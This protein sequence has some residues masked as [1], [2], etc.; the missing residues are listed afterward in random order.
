MKETKHTTG[1]FSIQTI[2]DREYSI[3]MCITQSMWVLIAQH[4][5]GF[6]T[7]GGAPPLRN[8]EIEYGCYCGAINISYLILH[9]TGHKYVSS[10]CCLKSLSQIASEDL[11]SKL[12]WEGGGGMP[13]D[14]P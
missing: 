12:S 11:N 10:K 3:H 13:P 1:S 2:R 8:L 9:V 5:T 6:H 4:L 7:D 14:P